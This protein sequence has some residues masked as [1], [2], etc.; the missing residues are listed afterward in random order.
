MEGDTQNGTVSSAVA[1]LRILVVDDSSQS[2]VLL[3]RILATAG[4]NNVGTTT[5]PDEALA[6]CSAAPPDLLLLDLHMPGMGGLAVLAR[7]EGLISRGMPVVVLTG[8]V[9][10]E[11]KRSALE[12]GARDYLTKPYDAQEVILRAR[13]QLE[14]RSLQLELRDERALL[15]DRVR[16][17]THDLER[18]RIEVLD[19]LA[20]AAEYRDDNTREHTRRIGRAAGLLADAL[21]LPSDL[22]DLLT[23]AA[24]LHDIGK[25]AIPDG[26]LLKPGPLTHDELDV[27]RTH[28]AIGSEILAGS[29]SPLLC[30]AR[31]I[32]YTHHERWDGTGYP[33]GLAGDA[34]PLSGRIVAVV[35]VFDALSHVRPYKSAWRPDDALAEIQ[36]QSGRHFDP[37]VVDAFMSLDSRALLEPIGARSDAVAS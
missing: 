37:E 22:T 21:G 34:I 35:D 13:N 5:R 14:A 33:Q 23:R 27:M 18:A 30:A 6:L 32:A 29:K 15:A 31:D 16:E 24:P 17:R 20:L 28:A 1:G 25:I 12:L 4:F 7:L 3:E 2:L 36:A 19:R 11:S 9:S 26:V 8:D 10:M